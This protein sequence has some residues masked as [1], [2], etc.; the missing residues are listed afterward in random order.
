VQPLATTVELAEQAI[1]EGR[2][3]ISFAGP[4]VDMLD[5]FTVS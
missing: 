1:E 4:L 5:G 2:S 3:L